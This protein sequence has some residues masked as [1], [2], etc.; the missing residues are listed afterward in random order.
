MATNPSW[1]QSTKA[2]YEEY[3]RREVR[4]TELKAFYSAGILILTGLLLAG[5]YFLL[6]QQLQK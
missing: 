1:L 5:I 2:A 3:K 4:R 6:F